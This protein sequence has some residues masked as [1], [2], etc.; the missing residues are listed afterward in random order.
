M[1]TATKPAAQERPWLTPPVIRGAAAVVLAGALLW[2]GI[3]SGTCQPDLS[4]WVQLTTTGLTLGALYAM[5]AL[6]YTM[7]YGV[8][9][10]LNFAHSEVFMVGS[11]AGLYTITK[12]FGL[13]NENHPNGLGGLQLVLV[14]GVG[15]LLAGLASGGTAVLME[16]VAYRPLRK[17]GAAR[18]GYLITAIGVSLFLSNLF[19]LLDGTKH[20]GLPFTWPNIAGR[21]PRFYPNVMP[22]RTAFKIA[23]VSVQNKQILVVLVAV[24]M[25]LVL[26]TFVRKT[27]AGKGIRAVAEDPETASLMGVNINAIIVVTF[28]VGGMMAGGAGILYGVFFGQAQFNMGFIPGIKAFTAA[29]LGGIGNVRGAMLG[30]VLLGL[31][32][33]LGVA[34]T[35]LQWQSVIAFCVLVGVLMFR[36]TGLLGEQVG[37]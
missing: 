18:L 7:V 20:L 32:E 34:C 30:G 26:D 9:Q 36:P 1:A 15:I 5:I 14:L 6:G 37:G 8:L 23:G 19:L 13:S 24:G 21:S 29:V 17:K 31:I 12:V 27:R 3:K 2:I 10:L 28:F 25:L 16:R 35:G 22:V 4:T 33:N 11:F